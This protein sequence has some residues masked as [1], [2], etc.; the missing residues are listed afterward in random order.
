MTMEA[1]SIGAK[2]LP[3]MSMPLTEAML[4]AFV[5]VALAADPVAEAV[6]VG[7]LVREFLAA[8]DI[9]LLGEMGMSDAIRMFV[10]KDQIHSIQE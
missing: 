4:A 7:T 3:A 2:F 8:Q 6:L 5:P 10:E 9:Q 1:R